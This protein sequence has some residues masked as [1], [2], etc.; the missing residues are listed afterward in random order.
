MNKEWFCNLYPA[1]NREEKPPD[2]SSHSVWSGTNRMQSFK[3]VLELLRCVCVPVLRGMYVVLR[4]T[5]ETAAYLISI[6]LHK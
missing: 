3:P 2:L 5:K 1:A 4:A 6:R